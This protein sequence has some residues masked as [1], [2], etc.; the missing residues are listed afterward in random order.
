[1]IKHRR[2]PKP[3]MAMPHYIPLHNLLPVNQHHHDRRHY[4]V[5]PSSLLFL[6]LDVLALTPSTPNT[7]P[8]TYHIPYP[9]THTHRGWVPRESTQEKIGCRCPVVVGGRQTRSRDCPQTRERS[10]LGAVTVCVVFGLWTLEELFRGNGVICRTQRVIQG[11][12]RSPRRLE[13]G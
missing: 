10:P 3:Q 2:L 5:Y 11:D 6:P 13:F 1:M 7:Y 8:R 12:D 4:I 9:R